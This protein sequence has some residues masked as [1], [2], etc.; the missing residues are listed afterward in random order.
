MGKKRRKLQDKRDCSP[1][2]QDQ[3]TDIDNELELAKTA[4]SP[5][6]FAPELCLVNDADVLLDTP[7][8]LE[9]ET[10]AASL[11]EGTCISFESSS[12]GLGRP[13]V[14]KQSKRR[15]EDR[16]MLSADKSTVPTGAHIDIWAMGVTLYCLIF[17]QVPFMGQTEFELFHIIVKQP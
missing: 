10:S 6:F 5:A 7:S 17:G 2:D 16:I 12:N 14:S 1:D 9:S 3:P 8:E 4:G 11:Q 15:K 13:S